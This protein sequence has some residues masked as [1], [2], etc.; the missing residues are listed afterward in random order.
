MD[1]V[2]KKLFKSRAQ[3]RK[4]MHGSRRQKKK[5]LFRYFRKVICQLLESSVKR[6]QKDP[7]IPPSSSAPH[8]KS[9]KTALICFLFPKTLQLA[10]RSFLTLGKVGRGSSWDQGYAARCSS[11]LHDPG[12]NQVCFDHIFT[13]QNY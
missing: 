7:H 6:E 4:D 2:K 10:P 13:P 1:V 8:G 9:G 3:L 5:S 12:K 11:D